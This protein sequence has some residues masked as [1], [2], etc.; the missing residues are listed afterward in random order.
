M[1]SIENQLNKFHQGGREEEREGERDRPQLNKIHLLYVAN[2]SSF[3]HNLFLSLG[4]ESEN[5]WGRWREG[6]RETL[7]QQGPPTLCGIIILVV[8]TIR[9]LV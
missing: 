1:F 6:G 3:I 8:S 2:Y 7:T 5:E 9:S 4:R